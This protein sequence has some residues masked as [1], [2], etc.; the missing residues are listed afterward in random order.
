MGIGSRLL[1]MW[2]K[3]WRPPP[4][5]PFDSLTGK[6]LPQACLA[7]RPAGLSDSRTDQSISVAVVQAEWLR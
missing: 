2:L 3:T 7:G 6:P 4:F 1:P 5:T